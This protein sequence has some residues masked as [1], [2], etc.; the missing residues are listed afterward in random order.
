MRGSIYYSLLVLVSL[1]GCTGVESLESGANTAACGPSGCFNTDAASDVGASDVSADIGNDV[2]DER[3]SLAN[4]LCG[5]LECN[6]DDTQAAKCNTGE[7]GVPEQDAGEGGVET[8]AEGGTGDA[9]PGVGDAEPDAGTSADGDSGMMGGS[10]GGQEPSDEIP[11]SPPDD[12]ADDEDTSPAFS[13][14][15]TADDDGERFATCAPAGSGELNDPC[16]TSADCAA[17]FACVGDTNAGVCRAYCCLDPEAC[18]TETYCGVQVSRDALQED[19]HADFLLPVCV[20]ADDCELLPG[21][22]GNNR[23]AEGLM[24]A[25]VRVDGTTACVRPGAAGEGEQCA[26]AEAGQSPCAEGFVCSK[27]T[28]TCLALCRTDAADPCSG[29]VCQ[30]GTG[31]IPDEYG[32]CVGARD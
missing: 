1:S 11:D 4:P 2:A 16:V 6:P 17:G 14:Q 10:M 9:E 26:P 29:G 3:T 24:C 23:C 13:C 21:P 7:A 20:P 25:I 15:V 12:W 18:P 19:P 8:G 28:N 27:S 32:V 30:G 31:G 5:M 22:D